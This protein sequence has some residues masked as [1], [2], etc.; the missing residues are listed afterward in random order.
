MTSVSPGSGRRRREAADHVDLRVAADAL[1][2]NVSD[3]APP[4]IVAPPGA[5]RNAPWTV[6]VRPAGLPSAITQGD[7][8]AGAI[9]AVSSGQVVD[10]ADGDRA[11]R[12]LHAGHPVH[13]PNG[14]RRR[15][16]A[17]EREVSRRGLAGHGGDDWCEPVSSA[18]DVPVTA[19]LVGGERLP[20]GLGD[21]PAALQHEGR[22]PGA[23][24]DV[25]GKRDPAGVGR[26]ADPEHAGGD[27]PPT[28]RRYE[29]EDAGRVGAAQVDR[30]GGRLRSERDR[31]RAGVDAVRG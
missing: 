27:P 6:A 12:R 4:V 16:A 23:G 20:R 15:V 7:L 31:T 28:P 9:S 11:G 2:L 26:V 21:G 17:L 19:S 30:V 8:G 29:P 14:Q 3:P 24:R 1:R 25:V 22:G 10:R 5:S 13:D 18:T